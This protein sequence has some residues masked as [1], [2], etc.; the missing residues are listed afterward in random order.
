MGGYDRLWW[1]KN[2]ITGPFRRY[3]FSHLFFQHSVYVGIDLNGNGSPPPWSPNHLASQLVDGQVIALT[4]QTQAPEWTG[5]EGFK[6]CVHPRVCVV[7]VHMLCEL[8]PWSAKRKFNNSTYT[9]FVSQ[10]S[11]F[12]FYNVCKIVRT[13]VVN[14]LQI[15][16]LKG[17]KSVG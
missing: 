1:Y 11:T 4:L 2:T 12:I 16:I 17:I 8:T 5:L 9:Y 7:C 13:A 3:S 14:H 10:T 15:S 6:K